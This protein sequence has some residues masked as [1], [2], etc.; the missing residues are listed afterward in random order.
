MSKKG[1]TS[2]MPG[3][4]D[5]SP[6]ACGCACICACVYVCVR[7]CACVSVGVSFSLPHFIVISPSV[8]ASFS[9]MGV[10]AAGS[11]RLLSLDLCHQ[12][13]KRTLPKYTGSKPQARI[14]TFPALSLKATPGPITGT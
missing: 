8:L 4:K 2:I 13:S 3:L 11:T 9:P 5:L 1:L 12:S 7:V 10:L 6:F 14:L